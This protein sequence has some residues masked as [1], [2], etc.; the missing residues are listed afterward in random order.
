MAQSRFTLRGGGGGRTNNRHTALTHVWMG[1][2][3]EKA[4]EEVV[5]KRWVLRRDWRTG[6]DSESDVFGGREFQSLGAALN[7]RT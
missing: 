6:R 7:V 1:G 2:R 5:E 4:V 3:L